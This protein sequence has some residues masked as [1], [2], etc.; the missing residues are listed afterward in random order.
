[1]ALSEYRIILV[2]MKIVT[3]LVHPGEG[4]KMHPRW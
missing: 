2:P 4:D 1:M 3:A